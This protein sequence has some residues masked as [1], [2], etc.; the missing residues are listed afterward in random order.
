[1]YTEI[2]RSKCLSFMGRALIGLY[3]LL[4]GVLKF[5]AWDQHIVLMEKHSMVFVPVFLACAGALEIV[6]AIAILSDRYTEFVCVVLF[7]LVWAINFSLH[8]FW[9]YVGLERMHEQQN[10]L[11]NIAISGGLLS[12]SAFYFG[13]G[14]FE[15][16]AP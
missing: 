3:F 13:R 12:L 16:K 4:P 1:M 14:N 7:F 2:D 8:D 11:K 10:F 5:L 15:E 9:N 6:S